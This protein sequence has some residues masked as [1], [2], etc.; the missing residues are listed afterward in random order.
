MNQTHQQVAESIV[1]QFRAGLGESAR[2]HIDSEHFARLA[3]L[4]RGALSA[5]QAVAVDLVEELLGKLRTR[6]DAP[7]LEL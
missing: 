7:Q 5:E 2:Q 1:E 4:I 3:N 6:V